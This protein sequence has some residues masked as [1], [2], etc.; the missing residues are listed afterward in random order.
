M[1]IARRLLSSDWI[2]DR[3]PRRRDDRHAFRY[4]LGATVRKRRGVRQT[5]SAHSTFL[6]QYSDSLSMTP[7]ATAFSIRHD[8]RL[9]QE[10]PYGNYGPTCESDR[11]GSANGLAQ[12]LTHLQTASINWSISW[13]IWLPSSPI[14]RSRFLTACSSCWQN[15]PR[16][17]LHPTPRC[18]SLT[19]KLDQGTGSRCTLS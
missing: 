1:Q 17:F 8:Q 19:G 12:G 5:S 4:E 14:V 10:R 18:H 3:C 13:A 11:R 16:P 7:P 6:T 2:S 15:V 9:S